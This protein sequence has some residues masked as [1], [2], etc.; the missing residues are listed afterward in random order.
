MIKSRVILLILLATVVISWQYAPSVNPQRRDSGIFAYTG[1]V[2]HD[3]GLPY[4]DAWD[5][6]LPGVFYIDAVAFWLF[7]VNLWALWIMEMLFI[8]FAALLMFWLITQI[9]VSQDRRLPWL[10][11][12]LLLMLVRHPALVSNTNF[13]EPY[14]LLFQMIVWA[15]GY[16][17]L[18]KPTTRAGF[19][20]GFASGVALLI[21]QT[22]VG[23]AFALIPAIWISRHPVWH[24]AR[25]WRYLASMIAGGLSCLGLAALFLAAQGILDDALKAS[26]LEAG[27]FHDWVGQGTPW[28][29]VT[30]FHSLIALSF[31]LAYGPLL[32]FWGA[33][34]RWAIQQTRQTI[35]SPHAD[36]RDRHTTTR[37]TLALWAMGAFVINLVLAN[38]TDRAYEH[39]YIPL[40]PSIVILVV[41]GLLPILLRN[42]D[43]S[44]LPFSWFNLNFSLRALRPL[45]LKKWSWRYL[46]ALL[47]LIPLGSSLARFWLAD[48]QLF[49]PAQ[50]DEIAAYVA[51]H[52]APDDL[53]W[54]WGANTLVNFQSGRDSP[55]P[56]T[57]A[58]PLIVPGDL[59]EKRIAEV[60]AD[61]NAKPPVMIVDSTVSDGDRV[62]PLD[63]DRRAA[64]WASGGRRDVANLDPIYEYVAARCVLADEI[65]QVAIY[66]CGE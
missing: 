65:G 63:A 49:G 58:Y 56:Y 26:F 1:K 33:G 39:Y 48:W 4:V 25:R 22:T 8:A 50:T 53:V 40:I 43:Q 60:I 20:I 44:T 46:I 59:S 55:T 11:S 27:S 16:T 51:E 61:L 13:T 14:A 54:V 38:I 47:I 52:T 19:V 32:L 66:H 29:G 36:H 64:W 18:Q 35:A 5:N 17:F 28:I 42:E 23:A 57:Y 6:K 45:R 7:G 41:F 15:A 31:V 62:P 24:D 10:G 12:L 21:K 3:G 37:A 2:I 30:I 34:M 9:T